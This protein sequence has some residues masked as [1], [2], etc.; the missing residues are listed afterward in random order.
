MDRKP[1]S[2]WL[3]HRRLTT[4]STTSHPFAGGRVGERASEL[5]LVHDAAVDDGHHDR[6]AWQLVRARLDRIARPH[7]QVGDRAFAQHS[8][9]AVTAGENAP[10][11]LNPSTAS[12]SLISGIGIVGSDQS[13]RT[14]P[15]GSW[16]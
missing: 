10:I 3:I 11:E 8:P 14:P 12:P 1:S 7:G 13:M 2:G 4:H 16:R 9:V 5:L 15:L 6:H